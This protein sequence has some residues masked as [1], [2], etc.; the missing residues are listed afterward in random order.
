MSS[1]TARQRNRNKYH[2]SVEW[3]TP[4]WL[5]ERIAGFLGADYYDPCP[6]RNGR[7]L[8]RN[9]LAEHWEGSVYCNPPYGRAIVPW[10][11]KAMLEPVDEIILLVPAHTDTRWFA[12]LL[13]HTLC[14]IRGRVDFR[15]PD[16]HNG[17]AWPAPHASALVYR[18]PRP[19]M[20]ADAFTDVG[21][22]MQPVYT[23]RSTWPTLW[24]CTAASR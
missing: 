1:A 9:G 16:T 11:R 6:A 23:C 7:P 3:Y 10:I 4:P 13:G 24:P 21:S 8:D 5:L 17:A 2:G 20:F 15:R 12:P 14:F 18:G 22:I 19:L